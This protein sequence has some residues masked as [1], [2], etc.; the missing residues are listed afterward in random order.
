MIFYSVTMPFLT[1]LHALTDLV[2]TYLSMFTPLYVLIASA[3]FVCGW[4]TQWSFWA[5]CEASSLGLEYG[6]CPQERLQYPNRQREGATYE[7]PPP[8]GI[9]GAKSNARMAFGFLV[10]VS[11]LVIMTWAAVKVHRKRMERN[12]GGAIMPTKEVTSES[13]KTSP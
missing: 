3:I 4:L 1:I 13:S 5:N 12:R 11:Y 10:I 8:I 7:G 9:D 2:L 6:K